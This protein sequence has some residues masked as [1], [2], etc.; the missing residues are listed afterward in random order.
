MG[1]FSAHRHLD[2]QEELSHFTLAQGEAVFFGSEHSISSSAGVTAGVYAGVGILDVGRA[3]ANGEDLDVHDIVEGWSGDYFG[4]NVGLNVP[5]K[6][7]WA[8]AG[9]VADKTSYFFACG[10]SAGLGLTTNLLPIDGEIMKGKFVPHE[11]WTRA[12]GERAPT[13]VS[14]LP[15]GEFEDK[16]FPYI[17]YAPTPIPGIGVARHERALKAVS[18]LRSMP[19]PLAALAT[20]LALALAVDQDSQQARGISPAQACGR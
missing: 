16:R 14:P 1:P 5:F 15:T 13:H 12:L 3:K 19:L 18:M 20:A 9:C 10:L 4:A 11:A 6:L 8:G 2:Y 17:Q 7:A